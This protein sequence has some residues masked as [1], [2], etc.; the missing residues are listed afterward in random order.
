ML[1]G[2]M[3][4]GMIFETIGVGLVVPVL[5]LIMKGDAVQKLSAYSMFHFVQGWGQAQVIV[6]VLLVLIVVYVFK[7]LFL[8]YLVGAQTRFTFLLL[9]ELSERLFRLYL[10]QDYIFHLQRNSA[11]LIR[12]ATSET[13]LFAQTVSSILIIATETLVVLGVAGLLIAVQPVG[14]LLVIVILGIT[15]GLFY[16]VTKSKVALWGRQRQMHEGMKVKYLQEGLGGVKD[17]ILLGRENY[18]LNRFRFHNAESARVSGAQGTLQQ[19]PRLWLE[20]LAV[21]GLTILV[22]V[23]IG[24]KQPF[25]N[26]V[27]TLGL[28]AAA[29]FRLMPSVNRLLMSFHSLRFGLPA[30]DTLCDDFSSGVA[31]KETTAIN[32]S[33]LGA[34]I[35]VRDLS[36]RYPNTESDTLINI[37]LELKKG[38]CIAFIGTSGAGKSTLVDV[39]LGLLTP[40]KGA[41]M[42][43]GVNIQSDLRQWQDR[44]GYVPQSIFLS[45]DT[46]RNNIAFGLAPEDIDEGA[47]ARALAAANLNELVMSL[48]EGLQTLVGERGVRLSGG[49]RQRIGIARALYHDPSILILDEATSALDTATETGVMESINAMRGDKTIIIIAHRLSTIQNCDRIYRLERG[50][51]VEQ[52]LPQDMLI[53]NVDL[54][55]SQSS[56]D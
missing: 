29:A 52:G 21:I 23:M 9:E 48:P 2:L 15:G 30:I 51:L 36:F 49:Q 10:T 4:V 56:I 20:L 54:D 16:K 1:L 6:S 8:A 46:L 39:M 32:D 27:P 25:E 44:L 43:D 19:M 47:L 28:F 26:I 3:I 11:L 24:Q 7:N 45:D 31:G 13:N 42:V 12:N 37:S 40:T 53:E 35:A 34:D 22:V 50:R 17:T 38:E 14:A 55:Q 41:I 5:S 33:I 18:F